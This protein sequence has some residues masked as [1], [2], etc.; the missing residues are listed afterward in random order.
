MSDVKSEPKPETEAVYTGSVRNLVGT[1]FLEAVQNAG[2]DVLV[3]VFAPWCG[4]CQKFKPLYQQL[5]KKL[6]HVKTLDIAQID[7]TQ[8]EL[9]GQNIQSYPT[10][11][12]FPGGPQKK[13]IKEYEGDR[14]VD[15]MVRFLKAQCHF[16]FNEHAPPTLTPP[17]SDS[18]LLGSED[19]L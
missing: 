14:T 9:E 12:F 19:D 2:K 7:G 13:H 5:G 3:N 17:E 15:D 18:G 16:S 6:K 11:L 8:N 4:H 10:I 1:T